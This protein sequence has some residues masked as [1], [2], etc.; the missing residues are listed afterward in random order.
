MSFNPALAYPS[1]RE[2]SWATWLKHFAGQLPAYAD[3]YQ[4]NPTEVSRIQ[5]TA[6]RFNCW[7]VGSLHHASDTPQP[8]Q[9][10]SA[11]TP[12]LN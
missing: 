2:I 10:A 5:G 9:H 7:L 4:V 6:R 1:T 8:I 11:N 12:D 3:R